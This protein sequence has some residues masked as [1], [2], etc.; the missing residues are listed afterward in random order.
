[1]FEALIKIGGS[2]YHQL[3]LRAKVT[4]WA[5]LTREHRL[6]FFPG[7]GPFADAVRAANNRFDLSDSAAHWMAILAMDQFAYLLGDLTPNAVVVRDLP[8]AERAAAEGALA[9]LAPSAL[10][11]QVDPL[12]HSWQVTSDSIAAWLAQY[13][14]IP[15]LVLL[16]SLAGVG[17]HDDKRAGT[18]GF[19]SSI[20][21]KDLTEY[22]IV[23]PYFD[24]AL[25]PA[26]RCWLVD[27]R[28]PERLAELLRNG[29]TIGT[30]IVA[31]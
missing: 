27:G 1:M 28:Q 13:A 9:I 19:R 20:P 29:V 31:G 12:P 5:S 14:N 10:L 3:N 23:D 7:G 18:S 16:K 22:D 15:L 26:T 24:Q 11:L 8:K 30:E 6:L 21:A 2:L 17:H 25:L 4:A